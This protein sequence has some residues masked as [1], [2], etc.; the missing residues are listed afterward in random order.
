MPPTLVDHLA[1]C[2]TSAHVA[3][4]WAPLLRKGGL[5]ASCR[6]ARGVAKHATGHRVR[7]PSCRCPH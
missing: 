3:E 2:P 1:S 4:Y 5:R 6:I 7:G